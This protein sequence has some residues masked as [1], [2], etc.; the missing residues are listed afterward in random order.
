MWA[1][2]NSLVTAQSSYMTAQT[3]FMRTM[4]ENNVANMEA[5]VRRDALFSRQQRR[6]AA[7][8]Q[9]HENFVQCL[10]RDLAAG[11]RDLAQTLSSALLPPVPSISQTLPTTSGEPPVQVETPAQSD[12][13]ASSN[14]RG[15][16][17][18]C[19][20]TSEDDA[21]Q[22]HPE[23]ASA[24]N[25]GP[26]VHPE[27]QPDT[28]DVDETDGAL[29]ADGDV[30][31]NV[32]LGEM[33]SLVPHRPAANDHP[34]ST[35]DSAGRTSNAG[36]SQ[37]DEDN[38]KT[39]GVEEE[40]CPSDPLWGSGPSGDAVTIGVED[41]PATADATEPQISIDLSFVAS[42]PGRIE[43]AVDTQSTVAPVAAGD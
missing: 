14:G 16:P 22:P 36:G 20:G 28:G 26:A 43:A 24:N 19:V 4:L 17:A 39:D 25:A 3:D 12:L 9:A 15:R 23:P 27:V 35:H 30:P 6:D 2:F 10:D 21:K 13:L 33:P 31:E 42:Q 38:G 11:D 34:D 5:G 37:A 41:S 32:Q 7:V 29:D 8:A 18:V 40:V 1:K